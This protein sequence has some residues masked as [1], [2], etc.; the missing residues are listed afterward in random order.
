MKRHV[1]AGALAVAALT[2]G[3]WGVV[4][5]LP[6]R[7]PPPEPVAPPE[8]PPPV[9][10]ATPEQVRALCGACH[11]YPPP[12][13]FPRS[14]WRKEVKQ[15]YDF[16]HDS[17]LDL[18][19]PSLES[20]VRY[21]ESRAPEELRRPREDEA[22][23]PPPV[24]FEPHG[25]PPPGGAAPAVSNLTIARLS[26]PD[27][28]EL[29]ACD[30]R[31]GRVTALRLSERSPAW[32]EL[33]PAPV[34]GRAEV[35]DL[36]GDG[37]RDVLVACLGA[38]YPTDAR[39]GGVTWLRAAADGSFHP[40]T[41]LDGV[42]RVSDV[43]AADFNGD[44]RLDLL[45]AVFG[46]RKTGEVL[47]LENRTTDWAHPAFAPRTLDER[48]GAI[49]VPVCDLNADGRPDFVALISQEHETV[50]AFLNEGAGNFRRETVWAAPHPS[51]GCSGIQLVDFD[52]DG[53]SD[54]LLT[55]GDSLDEA[56]LKPY[57]GVQWL[58]NR[59]GFPFAHHPLAALPGVMRAVAADF[60]ADGRLDVAAVSCL[61]P[62]DFPQRE[63]L[64]LASVVLLH[65]SAPGRFDFYT[66]ERNNCDHL[67]CVAGDLYGD[68]KT[69]LATGN[70]YF[71]RE[72]P[73]AAAVTV[74]RNVTQVGSAP[75]GA[76]AEAAGKP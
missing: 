57:H 38:F 4:T 56:T 13:T 76:A 27:R 63:Q 18:D 30:M 24:R 49:H 72:R 67:T 68:G 26:D 34:P 50:V 43:R 60:D 36:D 54:V 15:A 46:W 51:Y 58:E 75:G 3:A 14:V 39:V 33:G 69:H 74:W 28:L 37:R 10:E 5:A 17:V 35:V 59:G 32:R 55:N 66:L 19:Y 6:L 23:G 44:G 71:T 16:L 41:L 48:H 12:G 22:A 40:V 31:S 62:A 65:Q 61:P 42:G 2:L 20:V 52:R 1:V 45:V 70:H 73:G 9:A 7:P 25:H 21:Y 29:I 8:D 64:G 53:D 11:A 47:Y